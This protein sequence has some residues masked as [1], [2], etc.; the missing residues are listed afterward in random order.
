MV[1]VYKAVAVLLWCKPGNPYW[2]GRLS[3]VD[4]LPLTSLDP[5]L[6][7]MQTLFIYFFYETSYL[8]EEVSCTE[9]SPSVRIPCGNS[10]PDTVVAV[11]NA[12]N[13]EKKVE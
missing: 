6:L 12:G 9:P 8:Y 7:K 13:A 1:L 4:L 3:I 10:R 5:L 2:R 11:R